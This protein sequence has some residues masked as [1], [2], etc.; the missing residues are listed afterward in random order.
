MGSAP[1]GTGG[2]SLAAADEVL[3]TVA[4][5]HRLFILMTLGDACTGGQYATLRFTDVWEG[6]ELEDSG[7]LNY[8]LQQLVETDYVASVEDGYHL[9]LRGLKAYQAVKAGFYAKELEIPPF[10]LASTHEVC[11]E[12]L[13]AS[14]RDQRVSI[15]CP[16]CDD[17]LH[18]YPV[19]PGPFDESD[20]PE[21]AAAMNVRFTTDLC[22]MSQ[23][24]C[25]YCSGPVE[26][27]VSQDH[28]DR[29]DVEEWNAPALL[30][31]C[32]HC[33]WFMLS[34]MERPLLLEPPVMAFFAERG[35]NVWAEPGWSNV[36]E[37]EDVVRSRD[38]LEVSLTFTCAGDALEVVVDGSLNVLRTETHDG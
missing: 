25:P 31:W 5:E 33:H 11:G 38:P 17:Q 8:H 22:S 21:V 19:P 1:A 13:Y 34:T 29:L 9:T 35:V 4:N 3:K 16:S 10:E 7:R 18:Q 12:S 24:F 6:T 20:A 23:G 30:F 27:D 26:L 14:Y 2:P 28:L 32:T 36:L 37:A 15:E